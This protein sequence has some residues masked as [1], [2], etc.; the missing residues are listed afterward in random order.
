MGRFAGFD[1]ESPAG[2]C[3]RALQPL[4]AVDLFYPVPARIFRFLPRRGAG[5]GGE[6]ASAYAHLCRHCR[7]GPCPDRVGQV[8]Y[9][10]AVSRRM[11]ELP[12]CLAD[13]SGDA[14]M[15]QGLVRQGRAVRFIYE[16]QQFRHLHRALSGCGRLGYDAEGIHFSCALG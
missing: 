12:L 10:P 13:D 5:Q 11:A 4:Q 7:C 14:R 6:N 16:S 3:R 1:N 9:G 15:F 2:I 8:Q